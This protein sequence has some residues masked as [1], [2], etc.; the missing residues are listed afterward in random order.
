MRSS[1]D[2]QSPQRGADPH[3]SNKEA[4]PNEHE[5]NSRHDGFDERGRDR[6]TDSNNRNSANESL[7]A[8]P[9]GDSTPETKMNTA[10]KQAK[11]NYSKRKFKF[12]MWEIGAC[13]LSFASIQC[14]IAVLSIENNKSLEQWPWSIGPTATVAFI[15]TIAKSSMILAITEVIGQ[16]KWQHFHGRAN[17]LIDLEVFDAASRGPL[18]ALELV[19]Q[20]HIR[21]ALAS[22]ASVV[23]IA[24]LLIDPFMQLVFSFPSLSR[25]EPGVHGFFNHTYIYDTT[26]LLLTSLDAQMKSAILKA[27]SEQPPPPAAACP[28]GNCTWPPITTLGTCARCTNVTQQI[29]TNCSSIDDDEYQCDYRMPSGQVLSGYVY[30]DVPDI[31]Y[32]NP[33]MWN[34]SVDTSSPDKYSLGPPGEVTEGPVTSRTY[35]IALVNFDAVQL[36]PKAANA[37]DT[38]LTLHDPIGWRCMI[39]ICAKTFEKVDMTNGEMKASNPTEDLLVYTGNFQNR[40]TNIAN[41]TYTNQIYNLKGNSTPDLAGMYWINFVDYQNL[42]SYL[43]G[44]FTSG[45]RDG[46]VAMPNTQTDA[47]NLGFIFAKADDIGQTTRNIAD[48]ITEVL[49]YGRNS[50]SASGK[51]FHTKVYI[52]VRWGWIALPFT[53]AVLSLILVVWMVIQTNRS[54]LPVWKCSSLPLLFHNL[55]GWAPEGEALRG[56]A[57]L[58]KE[59]KGISVALSKDPK[60]L[61]FKRD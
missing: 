54:D 59:V 11:L 14:I 50:T 19:R 32:S 12:W 55:D 53:L 23:V 60:D 57:E 18:G 24:A 4:L 46:D 29:K 34:A 61:T 7:L 13:F 31:N 47:P 48:A 58:E 9:A 2:L 56:N 51:V 8:P 41:K 39:A 49:R 20:K 28:T 44:I 6:D 21:S 45:W 38:A 25:P 22:L 30:T 26:N 3:Q 42:I 37:S 40:S 16:L 36:K 52:Q 17:P 15:A 10:E 27:A 35:H 43:D 1:E 33:T 5:E